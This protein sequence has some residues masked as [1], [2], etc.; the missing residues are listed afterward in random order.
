[1]IVRDASP[2]DA[3]SIR[4]VVAAAFGRPDEAVIVDRVRA[5]GEALAEFVAEIDGEIAG[6]VLFNRMRC[7]PPMLAAGL[8]PLA[9]VPAF[10]GRGLGSAL[11]RRGLDA[12]RQ[13]GA[14]ACV[15]LGAPAYYGRF[16]FAS[17]G[18]AIESRYSHFPAFQALALEGG[19]LI[20]LHS[21][22]Y[23]DAFD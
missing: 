21:I 10:Q 14:R 3:S 15:V 18:G 5:A 4:L 11:V 23:P 22:A 19:A 16:G 20:Q 6:H 12:C 9:V 2:A 1:V 8:G 13:L 17:A 7:E